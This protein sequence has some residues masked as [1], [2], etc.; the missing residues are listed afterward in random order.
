MNPK[1]SLQ[2]ILIISII[3]VLFSGTLTYQEL[4]TSTAISCPAPGAPGTV[5]GYP[6]CV[7][8]F[9]MYIVLATIAW[10]GLQGFRGSRGSE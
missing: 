2:I 5:F 8:G 1:L 9:F 4:F 3:G 7:Y 6:A 10:L